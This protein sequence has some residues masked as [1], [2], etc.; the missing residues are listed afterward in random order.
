M[1]HPLGSRKH[2]GSSDQSFRRRQV[3]VQNGL[4]MTTDTTASIRRYRGGEYRHNGQIPGWVELES[5]SSSSAKGPE[6]IF[7]WFRLASQWVTTH[8]TG[9]LDSWNKARSVLR[10]A[11]AL[12][13]QKNN[14]TVMFN[15]W[16]LYRAAAPV[17]ERWAGVNPPR[18]Q[19]RRFAGLMPKKK[20][21][22]PVS[23]F[24]GT[25][26]RQQELRWCFFWV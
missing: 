3:A 7:G 4:S 1:H 8:W 21:K 5:V 23:W 2:L 24:S 25:A 15:F 11:R 6:Y 10:D 22:R 17:G 18:G 14:N 20:K 9:D 13:E 19:V 26:V 12:P 16:D